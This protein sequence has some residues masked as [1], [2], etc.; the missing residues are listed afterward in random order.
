MDLDHLV[1][2]ETWLSGNISDQKIVGDVTPAGY[3]FHQAARIHKIGGGRH[4]SP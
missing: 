2:T 4:S 1:I 3:S